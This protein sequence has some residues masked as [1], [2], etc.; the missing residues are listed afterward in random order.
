M[1]NTMSGP[2]GI[3]H[4]IM[5]VQLPEFQIAYQPIVNVRT[6]RIIAYEA[7]T[8]GRDG[9]CFPELVADMDLATIRHFHRVTACESI[10]RAME[11]GLRE[12]N[13][14]L[15]INM[16]PDLSENAVNG[17]FVLDV[18]NRYGMPPGKILLELTE[19]HRLSL[20][21]MR[22]VVARNQM[23][24]FVTGMDDFGAGYS[25]LTMLVECRPEVLKLDR[26]LVR[27]IDTCE[28]RSKVVAAFA[29]ISASL[30]MILVAEG[31]ETRAECARLRELGIDIM[32]GYL[33]SH[34]VVDALPYQGVY[35]VATH[36]E[37]RRE[38]FKKASEQKPWWQPRPEVEMFTLQGEVA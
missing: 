30:N 12:M 10:R 8:R 27:G 33:F 25:G 18:A 31:V 37:A 7:L 5:P 36:A 1:T 23:A 34:P 14:A 17:Q 22:S 26:A 28:T 38:Q 3:L 11:L 6:Q 2:T 24:G 15:C 9:R 19:D 32:Q 20:P 13:A 4:E 21:E 35:G 16:Q 29:Q